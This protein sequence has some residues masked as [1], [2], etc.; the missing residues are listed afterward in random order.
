MKVLKFGAVWCSGCLVMK[1]VWKK[2]EEENPWLET[3][4]FDI[5][6]Q[7]ELAEEY[8]VEDYPCFIFLDKKGE[9]IARFYGEISQEKLQQKID[10][11]K[12]K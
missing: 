2:L 8:H 5:D 4:Y 12:D 3:K 7:E 6:E 9:E 11:L 1:P 10:E